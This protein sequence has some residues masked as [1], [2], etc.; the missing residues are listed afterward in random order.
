MSKLNKIVE[1]AENAVAIVGVVFFVGLGYCAYREYKS[2][3]F[4]RSFFHS[5]GMEKYIEQIESL[6]K[7]GSSQLPRQRTTINSFYDTRTIYDQL[8]ATEQYKTKTLYDQSATIELSKTKTPINSCLET[9]P[10]YKL[11]VFESK[12]IKK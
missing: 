3:Q 10:L 6:Q 1:V 2:Q 5:G 9:S 8:A 7:P 12:S 11:V 4:W